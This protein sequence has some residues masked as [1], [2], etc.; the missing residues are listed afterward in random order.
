MEVADACSLRRKP[1]DTPELQ[2]KVAVSS[3]LLYHVRKS[4][5]AYY[6]EGSGGGLGRGREADNSGETAAVIAASGTE[7]LADSIHP[8]LRV[9]DLLDSLASKQTGD[10]VNIASV[11][12]APT[13]GA[14]LKHASKGGQLPQEGLELYLCER[15]LP[16]LDAGIAA[17]CEYIE[18]LQADQQ[19]F[20]LHLLEKQREAGQHLVNHDEPP[21]HE[22]ECP[23][24]LLGQGVHERFD[25]LVWLG[26]YLIRQGKAA[27]AFVRAQGLSRGMLSEVRDI[28]QAIR[29][30]H[31]R[32]CDLPVYE[33]I[34]AEVRDERGWRAM[35]ALRPEAELLY[36]QMKQPSASAVHQVQQ[37][38][39]Q[40]QGHPKG[41]AQFPAENLAILL[42][43][44]D[45]LWGLPEGRGFSAAVIGD[46]ED[47][48]EHDEP[49]QSFASKSEKKEDLCSP[50][51]SDRLQELSILGAC[52]KVTLEVANVDDVT[53]PEV[54]RFL[55]R[56]L[57]ACIPL[58]EQV[59]AR[60]LAISTKYR[61]N[62]HDNGSLRLSGGS[63][64]ENI[65][66]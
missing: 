1:G 19:Q 22:P 46:V 54:W 58:K 48:E 44:I 32:V 61:H 47:A 49:V 33:F 28:N 26:Q 66:C 4:R 21:A 23:Y 10:L 9:S 6:P 56:C 24:L 65:R 27:A 16:L 7:A 25:P 36:Q 45:S 14:M 40:Q 5:L 17:L 53:F 38:E 64:N 51:L 57:E 42:Q 11:A 43:A 15:L 20:H 41:A 50:S 52:T 35:E 30:E 55:A 37:G 13:W 8:S 62:D 39:Q 31:I 3:Y 59:F 2:K 29:G 34:A 63:L 12:D 60:A 18:R